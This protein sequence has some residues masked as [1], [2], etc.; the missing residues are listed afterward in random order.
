MSADT[1]IFPT[2]SVLIAP[3]LPTIVLAEIVLFEMI[4]SVTW[5]GENPPIDDTFSAPIEATPVE[6]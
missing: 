3:L 4:A 6:K 5:M 1:S 2:F